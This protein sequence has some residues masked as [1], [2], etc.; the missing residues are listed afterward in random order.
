MQ[1][2]LAGS[3]VNPVP[4]AALFGVFEH[5]PLEQESVV[6]G[7]KSLQPAALQQALHPRSAPQHVVPLAQED[8]NVHFPFEHAPV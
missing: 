6:H 5:L 1:P 8:E 4:Q 7:I 2:P 3:Q